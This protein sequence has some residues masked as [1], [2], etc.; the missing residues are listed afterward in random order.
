MLDKLRRAFNKSFYIFGLDKPIDDVEY[1]EYV[2]LD[3]WHK[4]T[5]NT[6]LLLMCGNVVQFK[7]LLSK[8]DKAD[9]NKLIRQIQTAEVKKIS[10]WFVDESNFIYED[11]VE[12]T[13][14]IID[15]V[16]NLLNYT[17]E[18]GRNSNS[19]YQSARFHHL[20]KICEISMKMIRTLDFV[21]VNSN[22]DNKI[23][24][25]ERLKKITDKRKHFIASLMDK[26]IT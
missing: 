23:S 14:E 4:N 17:A 8:I 3:L 9:N 26:N 24:Y 11:S 12:S 7:R 6:E 13:Y 20:K 18:V 1:L 22:H 5:I 15:L 19:V 10:E 16:I 25:M 21:Y 2:Q